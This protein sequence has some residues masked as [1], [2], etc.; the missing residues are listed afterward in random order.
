METAVIS[1]PTLPAGEGHLRMTYEE[2]LAW[3]GED[4]RGEWVNGEVIQFMPPKAL[5]QNILIFLASLLQLFVKH[6]KLG[7]VGVAPIE[8]RITPTSSREPDVIFVSSA[9]SGIVNDDRIEGAPDLVI[10]IISRDSV[11]RDREEKYD[12]YEA[13]GVRE[14][15]IIDNRT[16]RH[17]ADFF[18]LDQAGIYQRVEVVDNIF[19]S[20]VLPGFWLRIDWLWQKEPNEWDAIDEI[21]GLDKIVNAR[22]K[23]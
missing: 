14:Y 23:K 21:I 18:R 2:Y 20:E 7:Y 5:H 19:R 12:E 10:E 9:R 22:R 6:F 17:I 3:A 13:A 11:Q 8:V 1:H 15:W 16:R 4:T